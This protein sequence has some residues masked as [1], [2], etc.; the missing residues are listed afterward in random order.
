MGG[1][2]RTDRGVRV[3]LGSAAA[4]EEAGLRAAGGGG[5]SGLGA[6]AWPAH[7]G[8]CTTEPVDTVPANKCMLR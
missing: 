4:E 3:A 2:G 5:L 8:T 1:M 6:K 7:T